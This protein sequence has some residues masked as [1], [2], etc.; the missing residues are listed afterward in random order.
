MAKPKPSD[1]ERHV[2]V[3][4]DDGDIRKI[5]A[6]SLREFATVHTVEDGAKAL[7]WLRENPPPDLL[8]TDVMMPGLDGLT[9]AKTIRRDPELG[10]IS[11][12]F[13]TA[14][15]RPTDIVSGINAGARHYLT[16][17]FDREELVALVRST[18]RV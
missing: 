9:L 11:V 7:I 15:D 4:E 17:P 18:L 13:L 10:R 16:K 14:K 1:R 12:I 6:L 8:I 2:L 5:V 3:A